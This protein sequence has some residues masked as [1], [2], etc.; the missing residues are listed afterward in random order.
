M[1]KILLFMA[2]AAMMGGCAKNDSDSSVIA[3]VRERVEVG[4][5]TDGTKASYDASLKAYWET[6]DKIVAVMGYGTVQG[7]TLDIQSGSGSANAVFAGEITV[8]DLIDPRY[9]HFAYPDTAVLESVGDAESATTCTFTVATEQDGKWSPFL[10]ASSAEKARPSKLSGITFGKS[11]NAAFGV[12]VFAADGSTPKQLQ[13]VKI[14]AAN[15]ITGTLSATTAVDGSFADAVF[16]VDATG[17]TIT[18]T[19]PQYTTGVDGAGRTYYEYRFEVLPVVA[20]DIK[21][22]VTAADGAVLSRTMGKSVT[23][24]ANKR[25]GVNISWASVSVEGITSWYE[26]SCNSGVASSLDGRKIYVNNV[27][28]AGVDADAAGVSESGIKVTDASNNVSV[29][30]NTDGGTSFSKEIA[31]VGGTYRVQPY[32]VIN[33]TEYT[34]AEQSIIVTS[35]LGIGTHNIWTSYNHNDAVS[36]QNSGV[37]NDKIYANVALSGDDASYAASNLVS[38]VALVYGS[39]TTLKSGDKSLVGADFTTD[40][41]AKTQY[42]DCRLLVTLANASGK[43]FTL[44]SPAYTM[45][46]TG[47]PYDFDFSNNGKNSEGWT[48]SGT[49]WSTY[50]VLQLEKNGY[51]IS[52]AFYIPAD[53]SIN[54]QTTVK[55]YLY[56]GVAWNQKTNNLW[57]AS[58]TSTS[59]KPASSNPVSFKSSISAIGRDGGSDYSWNFDLTNSSKYIGI[60]H[61]I[62]SGNQFFPIYQFGVRYN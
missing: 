27:K 44:T 24:T 17:N 57:I 1:K 32:A 35:V 51:A 19:N 2:A 15:N 49:S 50:S 12:R 13:S 18:A 31:V 58:T 43:T 20:G 36:K 34:A 22:T 53:V 38:T 61:D 42:A 33:G 62:T 25:A 37:D 46:V 56:Y 29:Y 54:V 26:D 41:V 47:I 30:K 8:R 4:V 40:A 14:E 16:A 7:E 21:I 55:T 5:A 39:T 6:G 28:I 45:N 52:P 9:I 59:T 48:L 23:F 11:L 10:C 60:T 3:P